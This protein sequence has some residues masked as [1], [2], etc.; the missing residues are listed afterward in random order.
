ML[1]AEGK[2]YLYRHIRLDKNEPFYVG[3]GTKP[4]DGKNEYERANLKRVSGRR[5]QLWNRIDAKTAY[6]VEIMMESDDYNF[7]KQKEIEF[8]ALYGRKDLKT[9]ILANLTDGGDG[10]INSIIG[11]LSRE[12]RKVPILQ[13]SLTGEFIKEWDCKKTIQKELRILQSS[14]HQATIGKIA[15]ANGFQWKLKLDNNYSQNIK[16]IPPRYNT[17]LQYSLEGEFIKEWDSMSLI[18]KQ[19]NINLAQIFNSTKLNRTAKGYMWKEKTGDIKLNIPSYK[20]NPTTLR[21]VV[22][23]IDKLGNIVAE[24][25]GVYKLKESGY[26]DSSVYKVINKVQKH[27]KGYFWKFKD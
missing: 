11:N 17:I 8:I 15:Q 27:H 10:I 21:K 6:R 20:K 14:V 9:G 12:R 19:L 24:Y 4:N 16:A 3:I 23:Q 1:V 25:E 5:N 26:T 22:Q 2:H 18:S 13:Y 7:I